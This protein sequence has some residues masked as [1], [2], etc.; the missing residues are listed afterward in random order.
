MANIESIQNVES[1]ERLAAVLSNEGDKLTVSVLSFVCL[2]ASWTTQ[3]RCC[4]DSSALVEMLNATVFH[5]EFNHGLIRNGASPCKLKAFMLQVD[6]SDEI[7]D[8]CISDH[9]PLSNQSSNDSTLNDVNHI[10]RSI[11]M[12]C[13]Q[14][15]PALMVIIYQPG[16]G[17]TVTQVPLESDILLTCLN[18]YHAKS[19][20]VFAHDQEMKESIENTKKDTVLRS[21]LHT[22]ISKV[23]SEKIHLLH[24][25]F[26]D[27][28]SPISSSESQE[29]HQHMF[30][31][32]P[33][34]TPI[35]IFIAGD[36]SQVGKSS[37][38]LG[39]LGS[40]LQIYPASKLAYIKPATQCEQPQ[41]VS[42]FCEVK[43]IQAMPIGPLVYY[44]G[45]TRSFLNHETETSQ[46][47]LQK[48]SK[49]VDD[50]ALGKDVIIIDGVGYPS[51][52][53]ITGTDNAAVALASGYLQPD[54]N[55]L[56]PS[57]LIVG[58]SGVGDAVDSYYLNAAYFRCQNIPI[59]GAIF[60]KLSLDGYY[61]LEN[62]KHSVSRYFEQ[63]LDQT[64]GEQVYGFIPELK[65]MMIVED[66]SEIQHITMDAIL[67]SADIFI[68]SFL[69]HV[70]V[71]DMLIRASQLKDS[72]A[73]RDENTDMLQ[74]PTKRLKVNRTTAVKQLSNS[75][76]KV[77]LTRDQIEKAASAN[78][79]PSG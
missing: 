54:G 56:P 41:L 65:E 53:S 27:T 75:M 46:E 7:L 18:H 26:F 25:R 19:N 78:G 47:L 32:M 43:G 28:S 30:S 76:S 62:C 37:V 45:F 44:R 16:K 71:K 64:G 14:E 17:Y 68:S 3:L 51:V 79:A 6:H 1:V 61:S 39:L 52:G 49:A 5:S 38:C 55:R 59:L 40:L 23:L 33:I 9:Q 58:K 66:Q 10:C 36:R 67:S 22:A 42:K 8:L 31:N 74:S 12:N 73:S 63:Q 72:M 29:M 13:P 34:K 70:N 57:V 24:K 2:H 20:N 15:L 69:Q 11:H 48:I 60:N 35:R 77:K 21:L 50:I 4:K